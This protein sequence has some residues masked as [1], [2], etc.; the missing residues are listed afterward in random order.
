MNDL[1]QLL[2]NAANGD[3]HSL[4]QLYEQV[5]AELRIVFD[6]RLRM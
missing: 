1:T 5:Y 3:A 2:G 6:D 4:N